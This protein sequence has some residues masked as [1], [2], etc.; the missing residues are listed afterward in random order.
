[1]EFNGYIF[2]S[3]PSQIKVEA[4][5]NYNQSSIFGE[6]SVIQNVSVNPSIVSGEGVFYGD[7]GEQCCEY[8]IHMLKTREAG[9]LIIPG[10]RGMNAYLTKFSYQK[11]SSKNAINYSFTFVECP[12]SKLEKRDF[13]YTTALEGENA[14]DIANRSNVSVSLIMQKNDFETPFSIKAG[15]RVVIK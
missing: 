7:E 12:S 3:N 8:L 15:D 10:E 2:P 9:D 11:S 5:S 1:M 4:S 13:N 6:N 14:Y